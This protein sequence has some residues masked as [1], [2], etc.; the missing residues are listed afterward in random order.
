MDYGIKQG[1]TLPVLLATLKDGAGSAVDVS[2]NT[3]LTFRMRAINP[4][5][6]VTTYKVNKAAVL[7]TDGHD[8]KVKVALTASETDT[9]GD[10]QG[11]FVVAFGADQQTFPS[12]GYIAITVGAKA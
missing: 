8:G 11:E 7:N 1:D 3:G 10:Y 12:N 9:P 6:P 5:A 4:A 2:S